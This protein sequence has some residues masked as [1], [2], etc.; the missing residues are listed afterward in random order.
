MD[1]IKDVQLVPCEK[2]NFIR[3]VRVLYTQNGIRK[4]WDAMKVHDSVTILIYNTSRDV[5]VLVRQFR[6]AVYINSAEMTTDLNGASVI[7]HTKY[8]GSLG[9]TYELCAGIIDKQKPVLEIAREEVLEETG[10]K[11]P[12]DAIRRITGFRNGVGTSGAYQTMFYAAVTDDMKVTDGGGNLHEGEMIDVVE[13]P[14]S[15]GQKFMMDE[16]LTKPVG[17][18]FALQWFYQNVWTL[19][20]PKF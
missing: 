18:M 19:N 10:Y 16:T 17:V 4:Q 6:P 9:I 5:F 1:N 11:V 2:S 20:E 14:V 3:P 13:I 12:P 7:D 8:P 15:E